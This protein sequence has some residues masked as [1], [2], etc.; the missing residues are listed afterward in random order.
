VPYTRGAEFSRPAAQVMEEAEKL[1]AQGV[2]EVTLLGQNVNAYRGA[3]RAG[4]PLSLAQLIS[5]LSKIDGL[6]RIRYTTSH[7]RD[8]TDDLIA[9]HA[10]NEKLMPYLHLPI[11]AGSDRILKAMNRGHTAGHYLRLIEKVRAARPDIALSGDFI[12]GFPGET[13]ADFEETLSLVRAAKYATA[14]S[15]KYSSRPGTPAAE[16]DQQVPEEVKAERL[17]R[18]QALLTQQLNEFNQNC[19]GRT[20]AVLIEK[21]GRNPGQWIGRSPYL[22]SVHLDTT[23]PV[24]TTLKVNIM[25]RMTN[26]LSGVAV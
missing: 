4:A 23:E 20:L 2:R 5:L 10:E 9:A 15:F 21:P 26:S 22:Q 24:G 7:P 11:Q 13:D 6:E 17:A 18:L 3:D 12:T 1:V 19:V 14:Y 16:R 25:S 8:M